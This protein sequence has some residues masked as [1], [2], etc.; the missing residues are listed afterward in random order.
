[1]NAQ[2]TRTSDDASAVSGLLAAD[3]VAAEVWR[4]RYRAPGEHAIEQSWAR[5]ATALAAAAGGDGEHW[6]ALFRAALDD[7]RFLPGGRILAGAGRSGRFTLQNCFVLGTAR[8]GAGGLARLLGE[9]ARTLE[10]GGGIGCDFSP[11]RPQAVLARRAGALSPGPLGAMRT[12]DA[13]CAN[14]FVG[15]PRPGAMMATL[16]CEHPDIER[17]IAAKRDAGELRRFNLSVLASDAFMRAA[18]ND[19]TWPLLFPAAGLARDDASA[20]ALR[21]APG[22]GGTCVPMRVFGELGAR[23]LLARIA[24]AAWECAEPGML[25]IDRINAE[26]NLYWCERIR[27][28]NPCGEEPLPPHGACNLGSL[29]LTRFVCAPFTRGAHLDTAALEQTA[30]TAVRMLDASIDASRYALAAQRREAHAKRRVGLGVTGLADALIMLGLHYDSD[31]ARECAADLLRRICH[32]AYR[33]SIALARERGPFP[34]YEREP[35]LAGA[36]VSRLAPDVRDGIARHGL[37]NSHLTTIAPAGTISVLAGNV[38]SGIEPV[39]AAHYRRRLRQPDG[40]VTEV[41]VCDRAVALWRE[42][43]GGSGVP[44]AFVAAGMLSVE[45]HLAMQAALQP[46]VDAAISKTLNL[47]AD[48]PSGDF[49]NVFARAHALGLKGCTVFRP[50]ATTGAVLSEAFYCAA[51][52]GCEPA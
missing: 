41:E 5:V 29:N 4:Q 34:L 7:F 19:G 48:A 47:P 33:E 30:A 46:W 38:S 16:A 35:Y 22:S 11:L 52:A 2:G 8:D 43:N 20:P 49:A 25:F 13:M 26:N 23:E 44:P 14:L 28:T 10:R 3:P 31:A 6:R 24:Q 39:F 50:N 42:A 18:A 12:L 40:R 15:R 1:M 37:R 36:F 9:A 51:D 32:A 21:R 27:A 45:A 17:F